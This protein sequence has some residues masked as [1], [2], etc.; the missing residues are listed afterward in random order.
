M[1]SQFDICRMFLEK[2]V[3]KYCNVKHFIRHGLGY[4]SIGLGLEVGL[5]VKAGSGVDSDIGMNMGIYLVTGKAMGN[6]T[7]M[8][9]SMGMGAYSGKGNWHRH[10]HEHGFRQGH[11]HGFFDEVITKARKWKD[12]VILKTK[13]QSDC[14]HW[15]QEGEGQLYP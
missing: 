6:G 5:G 9:M 13:G 8:D 14:H 2:R 11:G 4:R 7:C 15:S 1:P 10:C 12:E 3:E